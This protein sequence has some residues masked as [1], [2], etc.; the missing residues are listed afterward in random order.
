MS[1]HPSRNNR[2]TDRTAAV[3][4]EVPS[5]VADDIEAVLRSFA[6]E[7]ELDTSLVVDHSGFLIAGISSIPDV[8]VDT[9]GTLVAG[10]S[11]ATEG[12]TGAL[13]EAGK[14]ESLHLGEDRLL[15]LK[16]VGERFIL[17]GVS[18]SNIPAG[19]LRD[20]AN[21]VQDSLTKLLGKVKAIPMSLTKKKGEAK[22]SVEAKPEPPRSLRQ[23]KPASAEVAKA[24]QPGPG[25]QVVPGK[26]NGNGNGSHK[27]NGNGG[28]EA[29]TPG[30][31]VGGVL[32]RAIA[33]ESNAGGESNA[34]VSGSVFDTPPKPAPSSR[35][36]A[37][38]KPE[39]PPKPN[40]SKAPAIVE[41]S[42]F[43]MDDEETSPIP[44][45]R[46]GTTPVHLS[47]PEARRRDAEAKRESEEEEADENPGSRYSFELG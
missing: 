42:P 15:Y 35:E 16:E 20:Q 28:E 18:D 47:V 31:T 7:A 36:E 8:D 44:P 22:K 17:V 11:G 30:R 46:P 12:L 33:A 39:S 9:I 2:K 19:I 3:T 40:R 6:E 34:P 14:V 23:S 5:G 27:G 45:V 13:G 29:K 38:P 26:P 32:P 21:Q 1:K 25:P 41:N 10:A 37:P 43:E 4:L 24:S